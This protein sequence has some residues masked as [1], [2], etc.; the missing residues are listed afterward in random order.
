MFIC[1]LLVSCAPIS[2]CYSLNPLS[3]VRSYKYSLPSSA[4]HQK[5]RCLFSNLEG[6]NIPSKE[7]KK[8]DL[9]ETTKKYGLEVGLF[10]A[11]TSKDA[12][13]VKP[14]ELLAK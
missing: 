8:E 14:Q 10:K 5:T 13:S 3:S 6:E 11:L 4:H 12:Q 2:L 1:L 7:S 9:E